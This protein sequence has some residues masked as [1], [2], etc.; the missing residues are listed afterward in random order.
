MD[1]NFSVGDT[2][3]VHQKVQEG[4]KTRTQIFEGVVIKID[5]NAKS[6]TVRKVSDGIGVERIWPLASPWLEKIVVKK[7]AK[8]IRRA[9]LY[10]LR[11]L[12]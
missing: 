7:K 12:R 5:R 3:A 4:D 10:Y 1:I 6:F 2:V 11:A 8:R 9:K